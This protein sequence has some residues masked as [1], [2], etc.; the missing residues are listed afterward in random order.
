MLI[1]LLVNSQYGNGTHGMRGV[2]VIALWLQ[3]VK[4]I[5]RCAGNIGIN[6]EY[7]FALLK[8]NSMFNLQLE[9]NEQIKL[10]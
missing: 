1:N 8:I 3:L 6:K 7:N 10:V 9:I 2:A 4:F 5:R